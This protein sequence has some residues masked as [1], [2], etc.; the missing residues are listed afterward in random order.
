MDD[1]F[2]YWLMYPAFILVLIIVACLV[3]YALGGDEMNE[4][5]RDDLAPAR[6]LVYGCLL[7][8]IMWSCLLTLVWVVASAVMR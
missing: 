4:N 2:W 1:R 5:E 8:L 6:G 3:L 7:G